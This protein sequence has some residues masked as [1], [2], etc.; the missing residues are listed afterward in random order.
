MH[1]VWISPAPRHPS[2]RQSIL[3]RRMTVPA[4]PGRRQPAAWRDRQYR[5]SYS[6]WPDHNVA[7][8]P[9]TRM[10]ASATSRRA[11]SNVNSQAMCGCTLR[12]SR[13][14]AT[15][16]A[17]PTPTAIAKAP[18]I[19]EVLELSSSDGGMPGGGIER[20]VSTEWPGGSCRDQCLFFLVLSTSLANER[21]ISSGA[22]ASPVP[23]SGPPGPQSASGTPSALATAARPPGSAARLGPVPL[24]KGDAGIPGAGERESRFAD[25]QPFKN[26]VNTIGIEHQKSASNAR[27]T[28]PRRSGTLVHHL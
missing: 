16:S 11:E 24:I 13:A 19:R 7:G 25:L 10:G 27:C 14:I 21:T 15:A 20:R 1:W 12:G 28:A 23:C 2:T 5:A 18:V 9:L 26:R 22:A 8:A 17:I 6:A 4:R 3:S